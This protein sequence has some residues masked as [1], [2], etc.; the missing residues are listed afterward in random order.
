M[1][2]G[3]GRVREK[4]F[5]RLTGATHLIHRQIESFEYGGKRDDIDGHLASFG[6]G[7]VTKDDRRVERESVHVLGPG[8]VDLRGDVLSARCEARQL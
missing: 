6:E 3:T 5:R 2:Y 8:G 7:Q 1:N 4:H